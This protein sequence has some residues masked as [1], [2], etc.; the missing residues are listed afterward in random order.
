MINKQNTSRAYVVVVCTCIGLLYVGSFIHCRWIGL[1][2]VGSFI[3]CRWI[4]L[5]YV[6]G[7]I[8]CSWIGLSYHIFA[9]KLFRQFCF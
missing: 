6:G 7:F 8:H 2:Y 9:T 3:H 1:A 5:V 4:G